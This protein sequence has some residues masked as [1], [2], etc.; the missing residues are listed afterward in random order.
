MT[1]PELCAAGELLFGTDWRP[2]MAKLLNVNLRT[3]QRWANGQNEIPD[4]IAV[5][6]RQVLAAT[7]DA[8]ETR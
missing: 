6:V 8:P 2:P 4:G 3:L 7:R 1:A 5:M